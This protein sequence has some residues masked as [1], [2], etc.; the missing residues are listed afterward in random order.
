MRFLDDLAKNAALLSAVEASK[1]KNG[2]P[3]PYKAAGMAI[4]MGNGSFR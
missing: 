4:G 3:D 1:D 2:Q